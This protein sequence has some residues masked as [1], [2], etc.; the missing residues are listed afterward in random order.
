[1]TGQTST[2]RSVVLWP[3]SVRPTG[4]SLPDRSVVLWAVSRPLTDQSSFE[5][6]VVQWPISRPLTDQSSSDQTVVHCLVSRPLSGQ[7]VGCCCPPPCPCS[8]SPPHP[9]SAVVPHSR[10]SLQATQLAH[11]YEILMIHYNGGKWSP[12]H[13]FF[14]EKN[15]FSRNKYY[16]PDKIVFLVIK[17]SRKKSQI[18]Y[19]F[20]RQNV[21]FPN[22][23]KITCEK[24]KM[25]GPVFIF[26]FQTPYFF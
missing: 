21:F 6:S 7:R 22:V 2:D 18:K 14:Q 13:D 15:K 16:F 11:Y 10:T 4:R 3:V 20:F 17:N 1:M 19:N 26:F 5:R 23:A 8:L 12:Y 9:A 25:Y 24:I